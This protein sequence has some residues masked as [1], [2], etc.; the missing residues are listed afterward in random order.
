MMQSTP[1]DDHVPI[2]SFVPTKDGSIIS[3]IR[4]TS[5]ASS[6]TFEHVLE[7]CK[8]PLTHLT[9][10]LAKLGITSLDH[11]RALGDLN[12]DIRDRELKDDALRLGITVMEWAILVDRL[13]S[14]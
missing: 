11:L 6:L 12:P 5:S 1:I 9:P 7:S 2:P 13:R 3:T 8:T 14:L 4:S 10:V